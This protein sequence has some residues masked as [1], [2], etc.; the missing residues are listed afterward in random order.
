MTFRPYQ[1][2]VSIMSE[3]KYLEIFPL[4][5]ILMPAYNHEKF[6]TQAIL[7]VLMQECSFKYRLIIGDDYSTDSTL[8]I[9]E[10]YL[11]SNKDRI[12][13]LKNKRNLGMAANY[14]SLFGSS[15]AKYIAILEG[16]DYWLDKHKL[17]KQVE[18]M[19]TIPEVG[20]VHTNYYSLYENGSKKEGHLWEKKDSLSGYIIG[21]NQTANVNITPLTACFRSNLAKENVDF[22]FII[23]NG[24][25]TVDIFLWAEVCRRSRV[26]FIDEI[27]GVY[28]IHSGSITGN[29]NINSI[30]RFNNTSILLVNYL[31]EK[32][33]TPLNI[34][35]AFYT[36]NIINLIYHYLLAG[37]P[38]KAK[39]EL[40]NI[41]TPLNLRAKIICLSAK[42]SHLNFLSY[43]LALFYQSASNLK[44]SIGS[45]CRLVKTLGNKIYKS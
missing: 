43:L 32:Y 42:Y 31:M 36:Q 12:L 23:N 29:H 17:Q 41:K 38:L 8:K 27:T 10:N 16:D 19:E 39:L 44:Q 3:D 20:L 22:D 21:P 45:L 9:C 1:N 14:K 15:T 26:F 6:I 2:E 11:N 28:R 33:E 13:L 4:V 7:S 18:I 25:L 34:K 5:D 40:K 30:A 35:E 37:Q 24:L